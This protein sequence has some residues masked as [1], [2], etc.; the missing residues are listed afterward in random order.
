[1]KIMDYQREMSVGLID[2]FAEKK[3]REQLK[4]V[5]WMLKPVSVKKTLRSLPATAG[6]R[7]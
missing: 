7:L 2:Q 1:M 5:Q 4:N 3:V 6:R